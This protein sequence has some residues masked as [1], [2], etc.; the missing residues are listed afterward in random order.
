MPS[1]LKTISNNS[2]FEYSTVLDGDE[3]IIRLTY[4]ETSDS[5]Y[6]N[7]KDYKGDSVASGIR[8]VTNFP[9]VNIYKFTNAPVG[10]IFCIQNNLSEPSN[11][12]TRNSFIDGTHEIWYYSTEEL[13]EA[14]T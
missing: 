1:I 9:L 7:L 2:D 6:L 3:F 12:P 5:W 8:I 4:N 14:I 10:Y 11:S 13:N